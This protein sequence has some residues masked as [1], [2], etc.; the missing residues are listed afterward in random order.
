MELLNKGNSLCPYRQRNNN[1]YKI[2]FLQT[3]ELMPDHNLTLGY[4]VSPCI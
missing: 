1:E 4:Y 2:I 3:C